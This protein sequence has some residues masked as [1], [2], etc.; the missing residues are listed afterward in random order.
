[1]NWLD[2]TIIGV[3][4]V[5]VVTG[6]FRGLVREAIS[7]SVWILALWLATIYSP[8]FEYVLSAYIDSSTVR[9]AVIF[10]AIALAVLIVGSIINAIIGFII[11]K[12]GLGFMDRL[13]GIVFGFARGVLII[14]LC[15]LVI[16]MVKIPND[17]WKNESILLPQFKPIVTWLKQYVPDVSNLKI[18]KTLQKSPEK[19]PDKPIEAS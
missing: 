7:L 10:F 6:L 4:L 19:S 13:F 3:I 17:N 2:Y 16:S 9:V 18:D 1:M 11:K 12:S 5:S 14:A 15:L 8:K